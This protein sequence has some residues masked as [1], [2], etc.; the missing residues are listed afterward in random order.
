MP[1]QR[2]WTLL[3]AAAIGS[4]AAAPI[5]LPFRQGPGGLILVKVRIDGRVDGEFI[6][7]TGAPVTVLL[8]GPALA[9][10]GLDLSGARKLGPADS[11][12]SPVGVFVQRTMLDLGGLR[13]WP[14]TTV[15]LAP[16]S[17]A[18]PERMAAIGFQGIVGADLFRERVVEVDH[19]RRVLRLH[20]P[21]AW[22]APAGAT[23]VPLQMTG[24]LPYVD[25]AVN[26]NG[27][28]P[29]L[30][31]LVDTGKSRALSL[32]AGSDAALQWP[33]DGEVQ[34]ACFVSGLREMR[35]GAP[36]DLRFSEAGVARDVVPLY[37][38][39]ELIGERARQGSIGV[40]LLARWRFVIDYPRRQIVLIE[41]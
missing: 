31:L 24:G 28:M 14:R 15:A 12:A 22:Q 23:I 20:E 41:R 1:M 32:V 10:L 8:D 36:V 29:T 5:E 17:L 39:R 35:R 4:A 40:E 9:P 19:A 7:D 25:V 16:A 34:M 13:I 33:A 2:W 38:P 6:V 21:E 11:P 37:E 27:R 18:C 30:R 3:L 26:V